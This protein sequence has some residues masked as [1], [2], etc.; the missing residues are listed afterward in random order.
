[1]LK[2]GSQYSHYS[3][4]YSHVPPSQIN[5]ELDSELEQPY[6]EAL[7]HRDEENGYPKLWKTLETDK[8]T[9][10]EKKS[11]QSFAR[12]YID[13]KTGAFKTQ[14]VVDQEADAKDQADFDASTE[15]KKFI[16]TPEIVHDWTGHKYVTT[17]RCFGGPCKG[18]PE[19]LQISDSQQ[20]MIPNEELNFLN[21]QAYQRKHRAQIA[22]R[23]NYQL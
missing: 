16:I 1:M 2:N 12:K 21:E 14:W 19:L 7:A 3:T 17:H 23:H 20:E 22:P 5:L 11:I 15:V 18:D 4:R 9:P 10:K 8:D 6:N 13:S